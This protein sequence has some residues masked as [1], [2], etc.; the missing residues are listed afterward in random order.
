MAYIIGAIP[1]ALATGRRVVISTATVGLQEQLAERDL[2]AVAHAI[3]EMRVALLKGR[4]RY[5]CTVRAQEAAEGSGETAQRAADLIQSK[6]SGAWPGDVDSL[7]EPPQSAVWAAVTNDGKGCAGRKCEAYDSCSYYQA[8][9]GAA[10]ANVVVVNH[11]LLLSSIRSGGSALPDLADT[12]LIADESHTIEEKAASALAENHAL[13]ET[14][15][16]LLQCGGL[17]AA[18]RRQGSGGECAQ[19]AAAAMASL[20]DMR[21]Q[22][23]E[24][25]VTLSKMADVNEVRAASKRPIR[26]RGGMLPADLAS[27]ASVCKSAAESANEGLGR[28]MEALQGDSGDALVGRDRLVSQLGRAIGRVTRIV[29][30]WT[31]MSDEGDVVKWV[32]LLPEAK[33]IRVCA[34]PLAVGKYLHDAIWSRA[35]AVIHLSATLST[36]GGTAPYMDGSGLALTPGARAIRVDAPFD[37]ASQ[38][39]LVVPEGVAN[40]KNAQEHTDWLVNNLP[41]MFE[42][43]GSGNG[44]L[45]LFASLAQLRQV[46]DRLPEAI[47]A[48]VLSQQDMT[49]RALLKRHGA[50]IASGERSII[51]GSASLEEGIDLPDRLCTQVIIAKLQF[52]VPTGPVAEERQERLAAEG[53]DYFSVVALP[54]ACRRLVQS[55][56]RLLRTRSDTGRVVVADPRLVTTSYGRAMLNALPP[57]RLTR[58]LAVSA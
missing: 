45:V 15:G 13:A 9:R 48:D 38:A 50:R 28:L 54:A 46:A 2:V 55:A 19:L 49:K 8:R 12:V 40:P 43:A 23:A 26:F 21:G 3:P 16:F 51:F 33:D 27:A 14:S 56:G 17:V 25:E 35:A 31:M 10:G 22:L 24:V 42:A 30:V 36:V 58:D 11:D 34:S 29:S 4:S 39:H 20:E 57:Y 5:L 52:E 47:R 32:E 37:Y 53:R 44:T 1:V 7:R 18:I 41:G 6:D